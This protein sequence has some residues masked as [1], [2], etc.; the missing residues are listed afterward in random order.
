MANC[1]H[2]RPPT[3]HCR[4]CDYPHTRAARAQFLAVLQDRDAAKARAAAMIEKGPTC[5]QPIYAD[6]LL[7]NDL[8]VVEKIGHIV[9]D[10]YSSNRWRF[11]PNGKRRRS[12]PSLGAAFELVLP[13]WA[14]GATFGKFETMNEL[15]DRLTREKQS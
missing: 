13:K 15:T 4:D 14:Y 11:I 6:V 1:V 10:G 2:G 7:E 8:G 9:S 5:W 3:E 12:T